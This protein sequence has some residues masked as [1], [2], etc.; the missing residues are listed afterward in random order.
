MENSGKENFGLCVL[1]HIVFR[2]DR[3]GG[4]SSSAY[5]PKGSEKT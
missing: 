3:I 4:Y 1:R 5:D 2:A